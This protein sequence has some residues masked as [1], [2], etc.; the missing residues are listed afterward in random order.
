MERSIFDKYSRLLTRYTPIRHD[1]AF[2]ITIFP[3]SM[4]SRSHRRRRLGGR[5]K[6]SGFK[7]R[8]PEKTA[9]GSA[10]WTPEVRR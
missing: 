10:P 1:V 7:S 4:Q 6:P 8:E 3:G 5:K 2:G 9:G